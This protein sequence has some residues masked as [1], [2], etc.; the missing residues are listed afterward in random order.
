MGITAQLA[1]NEIQVKFHLINPRDYPGNFFFF[2]LDIVWVNESS[3]KTQNFVLRYNN[4]KN[5]NSTV[6]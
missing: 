6:I 2:E 5:F 4:F 3:D 1:L